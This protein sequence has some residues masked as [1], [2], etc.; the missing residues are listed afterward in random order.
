MDLK[1]PP[2]NPPAPFPWEYVDL[3]AL[4]V[5]LKLPPSA[6]EVPVPRYIKEDRQEKMALRDKWLSG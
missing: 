2:P 1:T 3:D 5:D 6:L 4:L